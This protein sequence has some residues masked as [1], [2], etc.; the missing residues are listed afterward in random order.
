MPAALLLLSGRKRHT[1]WVEAEEVDGHHYSQFSPYLFMS[2]S[3][4]DGVA[5]RGRRPKTSAER[6][7]PHTES[8]HELRPAGFLR[9]A[10]RRL[11]RATILWP[12]R[13]LPASCRT[14]AKSSPLGARGP[15]TSGAVPDATTLIA[16]ACV[17]LTTAAPAD[18]LRTKSR[19]R[20][21]VCSGI[22]PLACGFTVGV[23]GFEPTASSSRTYR[24]PSGVGGSRG[25][26]AAHPNGRDTPDAPPP[27][28]SPPS[29]RPRGHFRSGASLA[30][31]G[32]DQSV[33]VRLLTVRSANILPT[34]DRKA[35][36]LISRV[37]L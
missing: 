17:H 1:A 2:L 26:P 3:C 12:W 21:L 36:F 24:S 31:H 23:A 9:S 10:G 11:L 27:R 30:C 20:T 19:G 6:S 16:S 32:Q 14:L 15:I 33:Q 13:P 4:T 29:A 5:A 8:P 35:L 34:N 7:A 25:P 37:G 18:N 22:R 28:P